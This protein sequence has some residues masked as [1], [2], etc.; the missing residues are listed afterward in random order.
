MKNRKVKSKA[1]ME[2][3]MLAFFEKH[4]ENNFNNLLTKKTTSG[5]NIL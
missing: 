3:S 1:G 5:I 4:A 2:K